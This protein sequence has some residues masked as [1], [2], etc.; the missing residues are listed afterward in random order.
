MSIIADALNTPDDIVDAEIVSETPHPGSI[1][2]LI[3]AEAAKPKAEE[4]PIEKDDKPF[5]LSI[6]MN[7]PFTPPGVVFLGRNPEANYHTWLSRRFKEVINDLGRK[8]KPD[9]SYPKAYVAAVSFIRTAI[10]LI[11]YHNE[12]SNITWKT[13][14]F[15]R[16]INMGG[17]I[18]TVLNDNKDLINGIAPL[19]DASYRTADT[20]DDEG[21]PVAQELSPTAKTALEGSLMAAFEKAMK[22]NPNGEAPLSFPAV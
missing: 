2:A 12:K 22:D 8:K 3:A 19:Y 20:T 15:P 6:G 11:K 1:D 18:M 5:T 7:S 4:T 17:V 14:Q 21:K 10:T 9:G 13:P 16:P